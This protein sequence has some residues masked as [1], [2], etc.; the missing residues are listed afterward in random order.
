MRGGGRN[1][2]AMLFF[3]GVVLTQLYFVVGA[4]EHPHKLFGYQ[5]F[6]ESSE[7]RTTIVRVLPSGE[8]DNIRDGWNGYLWHELVPVGRGLTF[9]LDWHRAHSGVGS[10]LAFF[11]EALDWVAT[12]TP[13]DTEALYLE[14]EVE[15]RRNGHEP[16]RVVLRSVDRTP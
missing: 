6:S 10:T 4:Y 14:A 9:P 11:Q 13:D 8:R 7:W 15:Y 16:V 1:V 5:P 12:H 3:A 2:A